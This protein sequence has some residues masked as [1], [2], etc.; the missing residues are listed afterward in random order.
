MRIEAKLAE[1]GLA[2]PEDPIRKPEESN[3]LVILR[4]AAR[5]RLG[6]SARHPRINCRSGLRSRQP[7]VIDGFTDLMVA[8]W[9]KDAALCPCVVSGAA[10]LPANAPVIIEG[11]VEV[12]PA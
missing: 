1:M 7:Q 10:E 4:S 8:L 12:R 11:E 3:L 5:G 6:R 9:G 2:L